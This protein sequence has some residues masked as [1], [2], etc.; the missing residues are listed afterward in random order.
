MLSV[1]D[2]WFES[3]APEQMKF[4][5][6]VSKRIRDH[7]AGL[8]ETIRERERLNPKFAFLFDSKVIFMPLQIADV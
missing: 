8:M 6:D 4:I 2:R 5:E 3:V 7:G 1:R